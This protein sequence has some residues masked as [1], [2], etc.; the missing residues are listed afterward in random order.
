MIGPRQTVG[1]DEVLDHLV[2]SAVGV[3]PVQ[4]GDGPGQE[5]LVHCPGPEPAVWGDLAVVEPGAR[6]V[7]RAGQEPHLPGVEVQQVEPVDQGD[8]RAASFAERKG[9]NA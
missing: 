9:S 4:R 6:Y 7:L 1:D 2:D 8:D 5:L 3:E